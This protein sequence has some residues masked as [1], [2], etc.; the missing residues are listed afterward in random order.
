MSSTET[1]IDSGQ[2]QPRVLI[3]EDEPVFRRVISF[4]L[5]RQGFQVTAVP[6]GA[7]A[8]ERLNSEPFDAMVTD[9]QMPG[10][11]GIELLEK[12]RASDLFGKFPI[13]LCTAKGLELDAGYLIERF[14]LVTVLH[15]PFSPQRLAKLLSESQATSGTP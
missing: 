10:G 15:K 9:H 4:T 8:W 5:Q 11:S 12:V 7:E 13:I 1:A 6:N 14:G 3:A 2:G